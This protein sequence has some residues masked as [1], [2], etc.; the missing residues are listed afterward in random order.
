MGEILVE[1]EYKPEPISEV[2]KNEIQFQVEEW[3]K[4]NVGDNF[5]FRNF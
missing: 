1:R 2:S 4:E 3:T 5:V